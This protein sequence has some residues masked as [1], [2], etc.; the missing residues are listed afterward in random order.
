VG[1]FIEPGTDHLTPKRQKDEVSRVRA[2]QCVARSDA[3]GLVGVA[4]VFERRLRSPTGAPHWVALDPRGALARLTRL[5]PPQSPPQLSA[6]RHHASHAAFALGL[7]NSR[8]QQSCRSTEHSVH[9]QQG[10]QCPVTPNAQV[11]RAAPPT[12]ELKPKN[13]RAYRSA[14]QSLQ[15]TPE[16]D[17][18]RLNAPS[19]QPLEYKRFSVELARYGSANTRR[20]QALRYPS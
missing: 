16:R 4:R 8:L 12:P 3:G 15:A 5:S 7:A 18:T 14:G 11:L 6:A 19:R 20:P 13:R 1:P 2:L 17:L 9:E 10:R